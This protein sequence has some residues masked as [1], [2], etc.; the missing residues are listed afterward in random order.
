MCSCVSCHQ[1]S[2]SCSCLSQK[3]PQGPTAALSTC[4]RWALTMWQHTCRKSSRDWRSSSWR[5]QWHRKPT[6]PRRPRQRLSH[7]PEHTLWNRVTVISFLFN[8]LN[9]EPK[10]TVCNYEACGEHALPH[11][12]M[13]FYVDLNVCEIFQNKLKL[14]KCFFF[15]STVAD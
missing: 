13:D 12:L 11:E 9:D 2:S 3:P 7:L 4:T 10:L 6:A 8:A 15:C 14:T 5:G 1:P